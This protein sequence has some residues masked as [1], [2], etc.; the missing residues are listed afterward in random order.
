MVWDLDNTLWDGILL[1]DSEVHVRPDAVRVLRTLDE[2]GILHSIASRNDPDMAM[3]KLRALG[4]ADYFLYPQIGWGNKSDAVKAVASALNIGVETFA[5]IDDQPYERDEVRSALPAVLCLDAS[6][7]PDLAERS[8]LQPRFVTVDAG[9]RRRLYQADQRRKQAEEDHTGPSSEFL[10]SLGMTFSIASAQEGDL[11]RL[12]E[13]T[14]RTH[15]LNSTGTTYS[16]EELDG[17]RQSPD[18]ELL[19]AELAD[20]Y[21]SYGKIGLALVERGPASWT[22]KL[23]L[24]SC[25]VMA[26][27][28]GSV[29]L[30]H[31]V[32]EARRAG[33]DLYAEFLPTDRNRTMYITYK[34]AGFSEVERMGK[35]LT[36]KNDF[37]TVQGF[38]T[39]LNVVAEPIGRPTT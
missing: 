25:R 2:R 33:V 23:L 6:E 12:E 17:F 3:A 9:N 39:H 27:G 15:Q 7:L 21:G 24:M 22:V 8:E 38:P 26:R 28:V 14:V 32:Q 20:K 13:L 37:S 19:V 34:F 31:L 35:K 5:F 1:E 18:H 16:Y 4:L 11:Q 29:L 10:A 30:S 36:L